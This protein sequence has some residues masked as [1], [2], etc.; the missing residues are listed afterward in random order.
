MIE[1]AGFEIRHA[2]YGSLRIYTAY[3][4]ARKSR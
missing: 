2:G 4:C 1:R 3:V